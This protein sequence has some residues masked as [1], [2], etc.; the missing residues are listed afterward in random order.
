M[1]MQGYGKKSNRLYSF[2]RTTLIL[3]NKALKYGIF[4]RVD[5]LHPC[6]KTPFEYCKKIV[7]RKIFP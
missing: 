2:L 5:R 4:C 7:V 6:C 1:Y 3:I